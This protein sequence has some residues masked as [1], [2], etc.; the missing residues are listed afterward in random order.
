MGRPEEIAN[1]VM[2]LASDEVSFGFG[3]R[4][5]LPGALGI[6]LAATRKLEC[7][8]LIFAG[9]HDFN[10]NSQLAADWFDK[11]EAPFKHFVWFEHSAHLPMSEEPGKH[12]LALMIYARPLAKP[13]GD[14]V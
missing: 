7:P 14:P 3:E 4:Y 12:L 1:A 6:N 2:F 8:L 9:R 5:L 13:V 11:V 10:V